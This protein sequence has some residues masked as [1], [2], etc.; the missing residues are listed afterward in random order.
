M[1]AKADSVLFLE[2]LFTTSLGNKQD[3]DEE[4]QVAF[5]QAQE[6]SEQA[7]MLECIETSARENTNIDTVFITMAKVEL[8]IDV[9]IVWWLSAISHLK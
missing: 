4:R 3:K 8:V 5:T 7:G 2:C 9:K 1:S 6:F